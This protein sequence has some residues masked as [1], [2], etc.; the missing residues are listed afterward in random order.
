MEIVGCISNGGG[1]ARPAATDASRRAL[2]GMLID[3]ASSGRTISDG[4]SAADVAAVQQRPGF[5]TACMTFSRGITALFRGNR[6]L[7]ILV[8]DRGRTVIAYLALYLHFGLRSDDPR[9]GL[10]VGRLKAL[11]VEHGICSAGRTEAFVAVLRLFGYLEPAPRTRDLRVRRLEPTPRM[12]ASHRARL[13]VAFSAVAKIDPAGL[14]ALDALGDEAF[15]RALVRQFAAQFLGGVR[16]IQHAPELHLFAD[17]NA[18]IV[19]LLSLMCAAADGECFVAGRPAA[20]SISELGRRFGVSRVHVRRLLRDAA[21]EGLLDAGDE[22]AI[23]LH[24]P[25]VRA[26]RAFLATALL[27]V[28]RCGHAALAERAR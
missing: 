13:E 6:L 22:G 4:F 27:F 3:L 1:C 2:V 20:V 23:V 5:D 8:N 17:R 21:A 16:L 18:G 19:V 10:T 11:S 14:A 24:P 28:G 25:L 9:S 15:V 7:N 12:L 26:T